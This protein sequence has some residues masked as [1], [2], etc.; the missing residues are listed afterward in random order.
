MSLGALPVVVNMYFQTAVT[1]EP[2]WT[3][4]TLDEGLSVLGLPLQAIE[5]DETSS[6]YDWVLANK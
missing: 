3:V 4:M 6:I 2:A 5:L 1:S